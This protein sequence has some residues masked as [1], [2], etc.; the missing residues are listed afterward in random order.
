LK[1]QFQTYEDILQDISEIFKREC[2]FSN[3]L[4]RYL[5]EAHHAQEEES[6]ES[7]EFINKE[8]PY[9]EHSLDEEDYTSP[10]KEPNEEAY[11]EG[12]NPMKRSNN[13]L[14]ILLKTTMT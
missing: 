2:F 9:L 1:P 12:Y 13:F 10:R 5:R 11:E 7:E 14:M 4:I 6:I 8:P 3:L